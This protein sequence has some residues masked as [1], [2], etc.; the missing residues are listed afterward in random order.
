MLLRGLFPVYRQIWHWSIICCLCVRRC[1][2]CVPC[3]YACV[4]AVYRSLS[5]SRNA[6]VLF[7]FG[8][9]QGG[10]GGGGHWNI[11]VFTLIDNQNVLHEPIDSMTFH[12]SLLKWVDSFLFFFVTNFFIHFDG[13]KKLNQNPTPSETKAENLVA[14]DVRSAVFLFFC[15]QW[16]LL[17]KYVCS[18]C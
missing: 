1:V 8:R 2:L 12:S 14:P 7:S 6:T 16:C 15:Q 17:G 3:L 9:H 18:A 11:W 4:C 10:G 13:Q 5:S